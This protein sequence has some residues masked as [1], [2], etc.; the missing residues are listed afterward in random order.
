MCPANPKVGASST[1]SLQTLR[2]VWTRPGNARLFRL[3]PLSLASLD[4]RDVLG[5][6]KIFRH[7]AANFAYGLAH[8]PANLLVKLVGGVFRADIFAAAFF[9]GLGGAKQAGG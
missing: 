9:F 3:E 8:F 5:R 7:N 4:F 6:G 2:A 1:H